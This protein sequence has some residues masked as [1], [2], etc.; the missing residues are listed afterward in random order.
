MLSGFQ[1][2][3]ERTSDHSLELKEKDGDKI[4]DVHHSSGYLVFGLPVSRAM[5]GQTQPHLANEEILE[6]LLDEDEEEDWMKTQIALGRIFEED[7]PTISAKVPPPPA[8]PKPSNIHWNYELDREIV[9]LPMRFH[10]RLPEHFVAVQSSNPSYLFTSSDTQAIESPP[11]IYNTLSSSY[12]DHQY[13]YTPEDNPP[14]P[15]ISVEQ[16]GNQ[17]T[18]YNLV[19]FNQGRSGDRPHL[20]KHPGGRRYNSTRKSSYR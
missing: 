13:V 8:L 1:T 3:S 15:D 12:E 19:S 17:A 16:S 11:M 6:E 18:A 5:A 14:C 10:S 2:A 20:P 9:T 7:L 4:G